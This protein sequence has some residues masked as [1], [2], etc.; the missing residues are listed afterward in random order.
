M[1]NNP[2]VDEEVVAS[3]KKHAPK[4]VI[5][6]DGL[7][8]CPDEEGID[9]ADGKF[10]PQC[11]YW[12]GAIASREGASGETRTRTRVYTEEMRTS[13]TSKVARTDGLAIGSPSPNPNSQ[14]MAV[15]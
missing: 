4:F 10:W 12:A 14:P 3:L 15:I 7:I 6:T 11:Q 2:F 9:Y 13:H 5:V 1:R 8:G